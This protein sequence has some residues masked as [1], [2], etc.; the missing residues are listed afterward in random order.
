MRPDNLQKPV[1]PGSR[2]SIAAALVLFGVA[3]LVMIWLRPLMPLDETRYLAVAW[4][5]WTG[6]S[7]LVPHLNGELYSQKPPMLFWL[8]NLVWAVTGPDALAARLVGP[9]LGLVAIG[10]TAALARLLW[11][12][13]A[14]RP[15][16]AA[17]VLASAGVFLF[18]G[19][20]TMF[21]VMLTVGVLAA[22]V[23]LVLLRRKKSW[24]A[25]LTLASG[26]AFGVLAKGP[27]V[28]LHV[29]PVALLMPL[30]AAP[31]T[32]PPLAGWYGRLG[33]AVLIALGLVALWLGPALVLGGPEY[34][35]DV[36]WRQS[37]G[38][39]VASFAHVEPFWYYL[40][41]APAYLWPWGWS[42]AGLAALS[43]RRLWAGEGER[44]AALW[45]LSALLAFSAVSGKL[46]H[47]L[48]PEMPA[49]ALL[50]AAGLTGGGAARLWRLLWLLPGLGV[51]ALGIA[52]SSG[53]LTA[54]GLAPIDVPIAYL[55]A[56]VLIFMVLAA[57]L[58][59]PHLGIFGVALVAPATLIMLHLTVSD[60]LFEQYST[61]RVSQWLAAHEAQGIARAD[62]PGYHGEFNFTGRLRGPLPTLTNPEAVQDW[63]AAHP[64]GAVVSSVELAVEGLELEDE[65]PFRGSNLRLYRVA[66]R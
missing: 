11:P 28:L 14:A 43:P 35:Y 37:A 26:L 42:G 56:S 40:V 45:L 22:L 52:I 36:L 30:W 5:M 59:T 33:L 25:V 20:S 17:L 58:W 38:R 54:G 27:V 1:V 66:P 48:V 34:R 65:T 63:A 8:I 44:F 64:G 6:G 39:V 51:L 24:L 2:A 16:R 9:A 3:V 53:A 10:L 57:A 18:Y 60:A 19:S 15:G 32:R 4:E 23:G 55:A 62:A 12:Q 49:V 47:Y 31:E 41:L 61:E 21:D 7:K 29:L 13:D 50:L 46:P